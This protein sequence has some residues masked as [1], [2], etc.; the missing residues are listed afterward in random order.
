MLL[1]PAVSPNQEPNEERRRT[2][3]TYRQQSI[4]VLN[5]GEQQHVVTPVL[6]GDWGYFV[7]TQCANEQDAELYEE[8]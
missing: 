5:H 7:G 8:L 4:W 3:V 1:E 2:R 6:P